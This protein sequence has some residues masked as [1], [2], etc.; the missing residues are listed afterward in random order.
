M[1]ELIPYKRLVHSKA[2]NKSP[3]QNALVVTRDADRIK[4]NATN[5][6]TNKQTSYLELQLPVEEIDNLI[7]VLQKLK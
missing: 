7:V 3:Y 6:K 2:M 4:F 1:T 5:P